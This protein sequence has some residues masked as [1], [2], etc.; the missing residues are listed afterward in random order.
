MSDPV[1]EEQLNVID[2]VGHFLAELEKARGPFQVEANI[3]QI[4]EVTLQSWRKLH[5]IN[6]QS[7][8]PKPDDNPR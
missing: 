8:S 5:H 7:L 4:A 2:K 6:A 3:R 1:R